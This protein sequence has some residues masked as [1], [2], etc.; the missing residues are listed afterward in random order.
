MSDEVFYFNNSQT[1]PHE[2]EVWD[3]LRDPKIGVEFIDIRS[4][5]LTRQGVYEETML[6]KEE[7]QI[8]L[9]KR[10]IGICKIVDVLPRQPYELTIEQIKDLTFKDADAEFLDG[11]LL[12][13][14]SRTNVSLLLN[15]LVWVR[16]Y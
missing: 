14:F 11:M 8:I 2:N 15:T 6:K 9:E 10:L 1:A 16:V 4:Y 13:L 12:Q 3:K 7:V 5:S